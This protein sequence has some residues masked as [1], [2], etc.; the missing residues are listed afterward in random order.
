MYTG[1]WGPE[2]KLAILHEK[3]LVLNKTDTANMLDMVN[4]LRDID[5]RAK[6]NELWTNIG[7]HFITPIFGGTE[8][9]LQQVH[10]EANFPDLK[11]H[12]EIEEAFHNLINTASQYSNRKKL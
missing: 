1:S 5:W 2:G 8:E 7:E 4:T 6:L 12:F 3:E 11:D 9:L 10:I